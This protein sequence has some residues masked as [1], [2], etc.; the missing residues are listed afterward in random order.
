MTDLWVA[1]DPAKE[2][3]DRLAPEVV[4]EIQIIAQ[5]GV[6]SV[7]GSAD[8]EDG[9]VTTPKIADLAVTAPKLASNAVTTSKIAGNAISSD[10]LGPGAVTPAKVGAG[11]VTS[12]DVDNNAI[13]MDVVPITAEEYA[14][15]PEKNPNVLY[16]VTDGNSTVEVPGGGGG[17]TGGTGP[18]GP[19]G[20]AGPAGPT[21]PAGPA[22]ADGAQGPAG[23]QGPAGLGIR[24][25]GEVD[26]VADLPTTGNTAGDL[27]VIG[28]RADDTTPAE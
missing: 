23:P 25:A 12:H 2:P 22:G 3:G 6:D 17:G 5:A 16:L 1:Y 27:W 19:A 24:Y 7:V 26:D 28:N 21:G 15:L 10:K 9:A 20:P 14:A 13:A 18:Q 4:D 8:L 11:V